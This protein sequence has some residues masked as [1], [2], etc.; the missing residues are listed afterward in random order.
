MSLFILGASLL[1]WFAFVITG[2]VLNIK[3]KKVLGWTFLS[4]PLLSLIGVIIY[5]KSYFHTTNPAS[6]SIE[7]QALGNVV[8]ITGEW[9]EDLERNA[10]GTD[11]IAI[12]APKDAKLE[13]THFPD[14]DDELEAYIAYIL[15]DIPE[16][17]DQIKP[18]LMKVPISDTFQYEFVLPSD[19]P[20]S[21]LKIYYL[22]FVDVFPDPLKW[23]KRVYP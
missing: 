14:L 23:I 22:H 7:A 11:Y 13:G 3:E 16:V 5:F 8:T 12:F 20:L 6:L 19:V 4:I 1:I 18:Q 17:Q 21:E 15:F 10:F 9:Q 2:I